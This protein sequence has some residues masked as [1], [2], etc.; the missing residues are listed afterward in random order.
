MT[1]TPDP[2]VTARVTPDVTG[3]RIAHRGMLADTARFAGIAR[4]I[5]AGSVCGQRRADA[6]AEYVHLLCDS[7]HHHHSIEDDVVWPILVA[8]A[9]SAIDVHELSDDHVQLE[10]VLATLRD[11]AT[12][13]RAAGVDRTRVAGELAVALESA[14]ALLAEHIGE[15][16]KIVFPVVDRY[17]AVA[18]WDR[19]EKAAKKGGDMKFEV[20][21][22]VRYADEREL[23]KMRAEAGVVIRLM[24]KVLV[25]AFDKREAI[26]AG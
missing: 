22:V 20:P 12:G 16:E 17:V 10:A 4:A 18:D 25:R 5:A 14:H 13:F 9:G 15:E 2:A 19:V 21:R 24:L 8:S 11:R 3:M 7:I 6:I 1:R 23:A 26:I